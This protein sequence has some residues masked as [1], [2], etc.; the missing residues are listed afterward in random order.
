M[1]ARGAVDTLMDERRASGRWPLRVDVHDVMRVT[2]LERPAALE[3]MRQLHRAGLYRASLD[4]KKTP[5]LVPF[6]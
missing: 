6:D 5:M 3:A 4:V 1:D 2:G